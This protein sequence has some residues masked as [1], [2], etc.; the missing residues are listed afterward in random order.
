MESHVGYI[1]KVT[2]EGKLLT[3]NEPPKNAQRMFATSAKMV[4]YVPTGSYQI[5][6]SLS[7]RQVHLFAFTSNLCALVSRSD[8]KTLTEMDRPRIVSEYY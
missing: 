2:D 6:S 8:A 5:R 3:T 1:I 4:K 7:K